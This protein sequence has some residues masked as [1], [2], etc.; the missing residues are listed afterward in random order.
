MTRSG[1]RLI[2]LELELQECPSDECIKV[3]FATSD[4]DHNVD[5]QRH[6][7][8]RKLHLY[9]HLSRG[10]IVPGFKA[11]VNCPIVDPHLSSL[12][13][14]QATALR[15]ALQRETP[16]GMPLPERWF[17][18][19]LKR[20]LWNRVGMANLNAEERTASGK[21]AWHEGHRIRGGVSLRILGHCLAEADVGCWNLRERLHVHKCDK[22]SSRSALQLDF[23]SFE[24]TP[25]TAEEDKLWQ[26]QEMRGGE[27]E[28]ELTTRSGGGMDQVLDASEGATYNSITSHPG[29]LWGVYKALGVPPR[30]LVVGEMNVL[31]LRVK[32][33]TE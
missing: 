17:V 31:V 28:D 26:P 12:G 5:A 32:K 1:R 33:V 8:A 11:R 23:P 30:S 22:G 2:L 25:G 19:P 18:S 4:A 13:R 20:D 24:Y 3:I 15:H 16:R 29:A 27:T 21:R 14:D 7:V 9:L 6:P 10:S